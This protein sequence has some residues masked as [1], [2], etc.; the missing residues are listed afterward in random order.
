[1]PFQ[2]LSFFNERPTLRAFGV[3][4]A[5]TKSD[6]HFSMKKEA[7][8]IITRNAIPMI[9]NADVTPDLLIKPLAIGGIITELN[10]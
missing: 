4:P 7:A 6:G 2:S 9:M 8:H 1:M 10:P 3:H 5:G